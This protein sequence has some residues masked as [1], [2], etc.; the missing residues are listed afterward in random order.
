M[1]ISVQ[2]TEHNYNYPIEENKSAVGY[3]INNDI[4]KFPL[5]IYWAF[6]QTFYK[7]SFT[8]PFSLF[9]DLLW[10]M[11]SREK[12]F[13]ATVYI[14]KTRFLPLCKILYNTETLSV[15][16]YL[17]SLLLI[18]YRKP[19]LSHPESRRNNYPLKGDAFSLFIFSPSFWGEQWF[20]LNVNW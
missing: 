4:S 5:N 11:E 19:S 8:F 12:Y 17:M 2:L 10:H 15:H 18:I 1:Q 16:L 9:R 14:W 7:Y 13:W 20:L 6:H 3:D